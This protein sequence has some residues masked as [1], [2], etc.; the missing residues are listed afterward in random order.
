MITVNILEKDDI[1][2][3]DDWCRPLFLETMS[4]GMSDD[5]SFE[6]CYSGKPENN[7]KWCKVGVIFPAWVGDKVGKLMRQ[8]IIGPHEFVRGK[9]P[10]NHIHPKGR[11]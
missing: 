1:L 10:R 11:K 7:V 4:G 5:Y 9:L 6:S 2:Q 8:Q 3:A